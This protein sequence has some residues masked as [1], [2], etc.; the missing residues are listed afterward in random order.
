MKLTRILIS[1]LG[2]MLIGTVA[3]YGQVAFFA[4]S[5]LNQM[6]PNAQTGL[7]GDVALTQLAGTTITNDIINISYGGAVIS[8]P[9]VAAPPPPT[10]T[11]TVVGTAFSGFT[12]YGSA[13]A[14][15]QV[16]GAA[17]VTVTVNPTNIT[18]AVTGALT[19]PAVGQILIQN[20][21]LNVTSIA[22]V[23]NNLNANISSVAGQ[24]T[25]TNPLV[26]VATFVEPLTIQLAPLPFGTVASF[27][28]AAAPSGG[29]RTT[30][31]TATAEVLISEA[32]AFTNAF[33]TVTSA[34]N[35]TQLLVQVTGIPTGLTLSD[36]TIATTGTSTTLNV[37][38]DTTAGVAVTQTGTTGTVIIDILGQSPTAL[39]T[40]ALDLVF[41]AATGT[42]TLNVA[43][44]GK[45][46]VTL[47]P[48]ATSAQVA[49]AA[50]GTA[51][52]PF[53][54]LKYA[55]RFTSGI[56][57]VSVTQ[58]LT[59]LLSVFNVSSSLFETGF[60]VANT[61]NINCSGGC[62]GNALGIPAGIPSQSGT[63][64][65]WLYPSDGSAAK[66]FT[67]SATSK[68]GLGLDANGNLPAGAIWSVLLKDLLAPAGVTGT[69]FQGMVRFT[70]NFSNAH[71]INFIADPNFSVQAQG[72]EM[73][74][75]T[76]PVSS[77]ATTT[78]GLGH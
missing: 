31:T 74:V 47:A 11:I 28:T 55:Q 78:E 48:A 53:P 57:V 15:T 33:E 66:T 24:A 19:V 26:A 29:F 41:K 54:P 56:T 51:A 18:I 46:A 25:L 52:I 35:S 42:T 27:S 34:V 58:L 62:P 8:V 65:V 16:I 75:V 3:S 22:V 30:S 32:G 1:V 13:G 69:S 38:L 9:N 71:G 61:T 72:Y 36:A 17:S 59:E 37:V 10:L 39:E 21:R 40:I 7:A 60:A 45:A 77:R 20:V 50:A 6:A 73:L 63:V 4:T 23:G 44:V 76:N 14:I 49:A 43:D 12:A 68:P 2:L 64:K 5:T 70:T 67:T